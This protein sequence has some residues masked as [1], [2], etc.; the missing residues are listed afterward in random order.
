MD[1]RKWEQDVHETTNLPTFLTLFS[2]TAS[3]ALI[4]YVKVCTLV[5]MA[6]VVKQ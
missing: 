1:Y 3:V 6:T 5:S 2:N 4:N